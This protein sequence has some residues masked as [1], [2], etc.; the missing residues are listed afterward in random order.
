[1][2]TFLSIAFLIYATMH[3]YA[4]GKVWIV[5]PHSPGLAMALA[6]VGLVM[7]L[8][9]FVP[10]F[11]AKQ[12]W[13]SANVVVSWLAYLWMGL[14]FLFCFVALVFDFSHALANVFNVTWPLSEVQTFRLVSVLAL[15]LLGYGFVDARL[16][17]VEQ[18]DIATPK[19]A[20]AMG[21]VTIAQISDLH[22][23]LMRGDD[24]LT[25]VLA[26]L[27]LL[28]PDIVVATGDIVD[29][30]GDDLN[31]LA[32][33]FRSCPPSKGALAILGNHEYFAG[34]EHSLTFLQTAGFDVLRGQ[35]KEVDGVVFAG[36]DDASGAGAAQEAKTSA[37]A[38]LASVPKGAFVI[39]LKHQPVVEPGVPFD[40]QLSGHVHAGQIFPFG[41]F[42]RLV[43]GV[44]TGLTQ[45]APGRW[46]YVSRGAGTWGPPIRLFATPEIT[47]F[48]IRPGSAPTISIHD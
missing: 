6:C 25:R 29:G 11:L 38:A 16:I 33:R 27:C 18:V 13:H 22:L 8:S 28:H 4:L 5:V 21:E 26:K 2:L 30:I 7:T 23:G 43:Y 10:W 35:T 31:R 44:G 19:L 12:N 9:P 20:P 36:V 24:V 41:I 17:R 39:L 37:R 32:G 40:L 34:I 46:L 47:L 3:L 15:A 42:T 45:V 48:R 14:L 1:M